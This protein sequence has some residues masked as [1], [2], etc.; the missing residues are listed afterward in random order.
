MNPA[1]RKWLARLEL[2]KK[3]EEKVEVVEQPAVVEVVPEPVA[4]V[5]EPVV[6]P[7]A[8]AVEEVA[9]PTPV[10]SSKKKKT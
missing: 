6:E 8:P 7:P 5:Q 1:K 9:V 4:V 10:V 2:T 3:Q